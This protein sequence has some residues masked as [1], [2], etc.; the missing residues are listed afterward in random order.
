MFTVTEL[1]VNRVLTRKTNVNNEKSIYFTWKC[2]ITAIFTK[3]D[4]IKI[5]KLYN[6]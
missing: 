1:T 4:V 6:A 2:I 5:K 3:N